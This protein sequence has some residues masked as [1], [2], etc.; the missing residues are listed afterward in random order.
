MNQNNKYL[1]TYE[2]YDDQSPSFSVEDLE[3]L[4]KDYSLNSFERQAFKDAYLEAQ[5]R[6]SVDGLHSSNIIAFVKPE[7]G[8]LTVIKRGRIPLVGANDVQITLE[9]LRSWAFD[10]HTPEDLSTH[11]RKVL[12]DCQE[13]I[14][15][16]KVDW[17]RFIFLKNRYTDRIR[18]WLD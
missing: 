11:Y 18:V 4:S 8:I 13:T 10:I 6:I 12:V 16:W 2:N 5:K 3:H 17:Y 7:S 9:E 14:K 15:S 1:R